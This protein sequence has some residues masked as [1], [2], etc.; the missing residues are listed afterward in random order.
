MIKKSFFY[1]PLDYSDKKV[2]G[3]HGA[4]IKKKNQVIKNVI[5][6]VIKMVCRNTLFYFQ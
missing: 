1:L 6:N 5:K 4:G 3:T 2:A